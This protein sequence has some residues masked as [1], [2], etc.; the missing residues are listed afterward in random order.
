M[1]NNVDPVLS[2]SSNEN[3]FFK[4]SFSTFKYLSDKLGL[5]RFDCG[6]K[7]KMLSGCNQ[8]IDDTDVIAADS[9]C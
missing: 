6:V 3:P 4:R 7:I 2:F 1:C 5:A 8:H 9:F